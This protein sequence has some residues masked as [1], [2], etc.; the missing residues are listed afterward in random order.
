MT[1][2]RRLE[3]AHV[4]HLGVGPVR[5]TPVHERGICWNVRTAY[6]ESTGAFCGHGTLQFDTWYPDIVAV[7][8]A[9]L[10]SALRA[11]NPWFL[12]VDGSGLELEIADWR[13]EFLKEG[14]SP[15]PDRLAN[16]H[17]LRRSE[18]RRARRA[19]QGTR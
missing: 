13:A 14:A 5:A 18:R 11:D 12:V 17:G 1:V 10:E 16:R 19:R 9:H 15:F 2:L 7:S 8:D 6:E 3:D 4:A